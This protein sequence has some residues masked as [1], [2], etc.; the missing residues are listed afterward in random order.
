[1]F[2]HSNKKGREFAAANCVVQNGHTESLLN[3]F[4]VACTQI[5]LKAQCCRECLDFEKEG[6]EWRK[7]NHDE[8][9]NLYAS[10]CCLGLSLGIM[11]GWDRYIARMGAFRHAY[12][13]L[14]LL[15]KP[16][17]KERAGNR[18]NEGK[19]CNCQAFATVY[20]KPSLF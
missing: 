2:Y 5:M 16:R 10:P 9:N 1:M 20:L 12:K 8:T 7:L 18:L 19:L 11:V 3:K 15:G 17:G 13:I 6:R 14:G 4:R